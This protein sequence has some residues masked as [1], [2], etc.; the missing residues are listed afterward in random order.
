MTASADLTVNKLKTRKG[1]V[2]QRPSVTN[3]DSG[4]VH[5]Q[6]NTTPF[7]SVPRDQF[8]DLIPVQALGGSCK[9]FQGFRGITRGPLLYTST[10]N[11]TANLFVPT[12]HGY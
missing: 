3:W 2:T 9:S 7:G 6:R 4:L 5:Q 1:A 12:S 10:Q 8:V 11:E